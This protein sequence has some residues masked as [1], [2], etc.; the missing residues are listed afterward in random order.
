MDRALFVPK[1]L[2]NMAYLDRPLPIGVGTTI[3]QPF[4]VAFMLEALQPEE[5]QRILDVGSGSGWTSALLAHIVGESGEVIGTEI[6]S[7]LIDKANSILEKQH[8]PQAHVELA[9]KGLGKHGEFFDRIL[10]SAAATGS[11]PQVLKDQLVLGGRLVVPV[12]D[13]IFLVERTEENV[14]SE[15]EWKGFSFVPLR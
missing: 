5:G 7:G 3:S 4:T 8:L 12:D 2:V 6:A 11:V 14:F 15:R 10:V 9:G 1:E 13:S